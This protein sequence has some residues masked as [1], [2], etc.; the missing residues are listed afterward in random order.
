MTESA[1]PKPV[2]VPD[3]ESSAYW[4]AAARHELVLPRCRRCGSWSLPPA[5]LCLGCGR[6]D[7]GYEYVPVS[8]TGT[9]RSWTVVRDSFL[10]GFDAELPFVLVDVELDAAPQVR[11]IGRLVDGPGA[12]L[13]LGDPVTTVFDD[14]APG[15]AIP[16]FRL[17]SS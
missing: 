12:P 16:E 17:T 10:P 4:A 11:L 15:L 6:A 5:P 3:E 7:S 1:H 2:P 14:R 9:I 8:K 13:R